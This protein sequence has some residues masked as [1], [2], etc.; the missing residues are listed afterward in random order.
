MARAVTDFLVTD[1]SF[2]RNLVGPCWFSLF[3]EERECLAQVLQWR[4]TT[5]SL[6]LILGTMNGSSRP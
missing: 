1:M 2:E 4:W 5:S 6:P 3:N